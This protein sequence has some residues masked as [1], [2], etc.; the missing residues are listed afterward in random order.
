M[1]STFW[2]GVGACALAAFTAHAGTIRASIDAD[3]V[4]KGVPFQIVLEIAGRDVARVDVPE[5]DGATIDSQPN[6]SGTQ[7]NYVR[8][9]LT[10]T[11]TLG[12]MVTPQRAGEL[13]V[14]AF[15]AEVD[16]ETIASE[17]V[18]VTVLDSPK[19]DDSEAR[20]VAGD[21]VLFTQ[22]KTDK[23]DA[24][25]GEAIAL[26]MEVWILDGAR[27]RYEPAGFPELTGFYALPREPGQPGERMSTRD[28]QRYKVVTFAQTLFPASSGDLRIGPWTWTCDVAYRGM[29]RGRQ[30]KTDPFTIAV[31]PLPSP[32][33]GFSGSVGTYQ[34]VAALSAKT[35][36]VGVPVSLTIG[37]VGDGN[38][39]AIGTPRLPAIDGAY[40]DE[41]QRAV[42]GVQPGGTSGE[43]FVYKLTP[44]RAGDIRVPAIEYVYF[45]PS[46]DSYQT[47]RTEPL[48]LAVRATAKPEDQVVVG[49]G[50]TENTAPSVGPDIVEL[51]GDPGPIRPEDNR[52]IP[53]TVAALAPAAA[54]GAFALFVRRRRRFQTDRAFARAYGALRTG[55]ERLC[56]ARHAD[57]PEDA[58]YRAVTGYVADQFNLPETGMTSAEAQLFFESRQVPAD[59]AD[60]FHKVLKACERARY[61]A[62]RLTADEVEAL[63]QGAQ[64]GMERLDAHLKRGRAA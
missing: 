34:A 28:G 33:D 20:S 17:P 37:I 16:G 35:A 4:T 29:A 38:P 62:S 60:T 32:P 19:T 50:G 31:K 58:L 48:V 42:L 27:V 1:R 41:P 45:D 56:A 36:D 39:D 11:K 30:I 2:S 63:I 15:T 46:Q 12:Y 6:Y 7:I 47:A 64:T 13:V 8:G 3:T 5:T 55:T 14:P 22:I 51:T 21:Q 57:R 53:T 59:A 9:T 18:R 43:N 61:A 23:K 10:T 52:T 26:S 25:Q 54:Y 40:I 44:Q 24:Y 49:A